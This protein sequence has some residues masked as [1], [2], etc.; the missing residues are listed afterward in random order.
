V[1]DCRPGAEQTSTATAHLTI[2]KEITIN[3]VWM[4]FVHCRVI[5]NIRRPPFRRLKKHPD[6]DRLNKKREAVL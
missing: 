6:H 5:K 1:L 4:S 2:S 3:A